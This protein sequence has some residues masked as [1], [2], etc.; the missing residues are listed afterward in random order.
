MRQITFIMLIALFTA[1]GAIADQPMERSEILGLLGRL[2][3]RPRAAWMQGG[4]IEAVH[5]SSDLITGKVTETL[6]TVTTDGNRFTWQI[7]IASCANRAKLNKMHTDDFMQWNR[8]RTFIWDGL[9]YTLYF[10]P[11]NHAIIYEEP[12]I[13]VN[14]TGP[15]TAGHIPWGEGA[16]S[17]ESLT[18]GRLSAMK[19]QAEDGLQ[20]HLSIQPAGRPLMEFVLDPSRNDAVLSYTLI[21]SDDSRVTQTYGNFQEWQCGW[22]PMNILIDRYKNDQLR[23]TDE[24]EF[25]FLQDTDLPQTAFNAQFKEKTLV[26]YY[27]PLLDKPVFYRHHIGRNIEPLLE[28]RFITACKEDLQKQNCGIVATEQ[29]LSVFGIS[30]TDQELTSLVHTDSGETSLY[31]IRQLIQQKGLYCLPVKTDMMALK[32]Y[33]DV[34]FILY[35]P[36]KKH[37]VVL[38]RIDDADVWIIDLD[39]QTFFHNMN[40]SQFKQE[41]TGIALIVSNKPLS[42]RDNDRPIPDPVLS[43]ITGSADYSCSDLIQQYDVVFCPGMV[44]G[45]CGG[46]YEMWYER[47]AC[48]I[49]TNGGYCD[50]T[51]VVGS[52]YSTCIEDTADPGQCTTTGNYISRYMRACQP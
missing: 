7:Q 12:T 38:D 44:Q 11:G 15:L 27:S 34:Q 32:Q 2:C 9:T 19:V 13:P 29:V 4:R 3:Q 18:S 28:K 49:D 6:E 26:E 1:P 36:N 39:R 48:E 5:R 17:F 31:E 47:Y 10:E 51:G 14:V 52:V 22:I 21:Q 46:R 24:W 16:F 37:F 35:F 42:M 41:W 43:N 33:Q 8:T 45:D 30:S 40:L 23:S 50:G 25:V 20:V